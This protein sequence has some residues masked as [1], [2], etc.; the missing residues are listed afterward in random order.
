[1]LSGLLEAVMA[2][3]QES[4][5][6]RNGFR[7]FNELDGNGERAIGVE[8]L[9]NA[10]SP[11]ACFFSIVR[12]GSRELANIF[13]IET[14]QFDWDFRALRGS[15]DIQNK[16]AVK[17]DVLS[18]AVFTE[19]PNWLT[20]G[21]MNDLKLH[22]KNINRRSVMRAHETAFL[23]RERAAFDEW[24]AQNPLLVEEEEEEEQQQQQQEEEARPG[25]AP[26]PAEVAPAEPAVPAFEIERIRIPNPT[27]R[28]R[29][30]Y[31]PLGPVEK[32]ICDGEDQ[33][34][35][36]EFPNN[37]IVVSENGE[38]SDFFQELGYVCL[39][40]SFGDRGLRIDK[41]KIFS[42]K[43]W[44]AGSHYLDFYVYNKKNL[45]IYTNDSETVTG[46]AR[47]A[48]K[49]NRESC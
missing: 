37:F 47:I 27:P 48:L 38:R 6:I 9:F 44:S 19:E 36:A 15:P 24:L 22:L 5:G 25:P 40:G 10:N 33:N 35:N 12:F 39:A 45:K 16:L 17:R 28:P 46:L 14:L 1:M 32:G 34:T 49:V 21:E 3:A 13:G 7:I 26:Q 30:S 43:N 20:A 23:H 42:L 29:E 4:L 31:V 11:G 8:S 41:S 18:R 2:K